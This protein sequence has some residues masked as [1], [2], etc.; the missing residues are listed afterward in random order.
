MYE[1]MSSVMNGARQI[2]KAQAINANNLANVSTTGFKG[3]L[4]HVMGTSTA[5]GLKSS[6]DMSNG[7]LKTT[8]RPLD[9]S[10]DGKGWIA[11]VA[12]DGTEAYSRRGDF[13]LDAL[14]QLTDGRG[15]PIIGN[16]GPIALPP[17]SS[18]EIAG[19]GSISILPMG[20]ENAELAV[21]D[22]IKLVVP[23][24]GQLQRGEDGLMRVADNIVLPPD[25]SVR[26]LSGTLEGSNVNAVGEMV[27]MIDLARQ[28]EAQIQLMQSAKENASVLAELLSMN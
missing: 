15:R 10:V 19:D 14:G 28:F 17:F 7:M 27:K 26:V 3:E 20:S 25:G 9:I 2:M 12:E 16:S 18:L 13:R 8:G 11:I 21:V 4:A 24:T 1:I 23:E 6:P 22:R 5:D